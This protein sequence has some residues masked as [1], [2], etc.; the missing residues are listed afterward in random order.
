[1]G[2]R[3]MKAPNDNQQ[4]TMQ[5][6]MLKSEIEAIRKSH[7]YNRELLMSDAGSDTGISCGSGNNI[8]ALK[9]C[10]CCGQLTLPAYSEYEVCPICGWIDDPYQNQ[11]PSSAVGKNPISLLEVRERYMKQT[12]KPEY[13]M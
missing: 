2:G 10:A 5:S 11:H 9:K 4:T 13:Y 8:C 1:M 6:Y 3:G 7:E 12:E